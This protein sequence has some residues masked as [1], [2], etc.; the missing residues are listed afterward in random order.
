MRRLKEASNLSTIKNN[1]RSLILRVLNAMGQVSRADLAR[2]T[3]LTKTSITNIAGELI[4]EGLVYETGTADS[5]SGRKPIML[6]LNEQALNA[7]GVYISRDFVYTNIANLKGKVMMEEKLSLDFT[8]NEH[9]LLSKIFSSIERLLADSAVE[10]TKILGAGVA[11]IGPLN[12]KEGIILDPPNFRGLRSIHIVNALEERFGL[13]VFLDNDM[14]ASAIAE[15]LFGNAKN[16]SNFIYIG[17]TNGIGAGIFLNNE[18]FRGLNGFAGEIGHTT[19]DMRGE[20]CPCGNLGCLELYASIPNAVNEV[21]ASTGNGASGSFTQTENITWSGIVDAAKAG[22]RLCI[23]VID[24]LTYYISVGIVNTV[25]SFDP[26]TIFLGHDIALA[27]ELVLKPLNDMV[28]RSF[29]FRNSEH[30]NIELSKFG[31]Y[32]PCIGAPA[33]VLNKFFAGQLLN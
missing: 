6:N 32:S 2:I 31:V 14:N 4:K 12:I 7:I 23:R 22:D 3:G 13:K 19:V 15:K 27:G 25:N 26:E 1:N 30:V 21:K 9:S 5:P 24:K 33:I 16:V 28:N 20:R 18:I 8:E 17:I 11:S 10:R 29:M